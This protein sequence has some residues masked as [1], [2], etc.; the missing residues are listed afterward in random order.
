VRLEDLDYFLAV[1]EAGHVGR[2]S[3]RLGATQ[4]ALTKGV[5]RLER[6]LKLQLFERTAKG[7]SLTAAGETFYERVRNVRSGLNDA[8][9]EAND[10]HLGKVGLV[11]AGISPIYV[12][13]FFRDACTELLQQRPAAR[14]QVT[15]GLND[16]LFAAL[17][18]GD[19]DF[20]ISALLNA[21]DSE[22]EREPLFTDNL[23][24]V[25]R[26]GHPIFLAADL[27][28]SDLA[29]ASWLLPGGQVMARRAVEASFAKHGLPPPN[30]V[31][32][33][34]STIASMMG[35]VKATDLLSVTGES[36]LRLPNGAGLR[37][38]PLQEA[39]WPRVVGITTRRGAYLSPLTQRM[40]ELL[41]QRGGLRSAE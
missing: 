29:K 25:A 12:E 32:E 3:E 14:V 9:K 37:P 23:Q 1:A 27:Q 33:S 26:E 11:R 36:M 16:K 28:F 2:A 7:M 13:H 17:R 31:I 38:V 41:R 30:V 5:Q 40:L 8:I 20:S 6:E 18:A 21:N 24:V 4:P 19:L 10:L 35:L 34:N 39:S 15:I 22:F